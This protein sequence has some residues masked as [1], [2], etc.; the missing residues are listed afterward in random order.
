MNSQT[1]RQRVH[2]RLLRGAIEKAYCAGTHLGSSSESATRQLHDLGKLPHLAKPQ[3]LSCTK[4][5]LIPA[6]K[7]LQ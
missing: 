1:S 4:E 7:G 6:L 5:R 2:G 3:S